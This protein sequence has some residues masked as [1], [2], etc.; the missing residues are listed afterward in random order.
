M[1]PTRWC[2]CQGV[3]L[4]LLLMPPAHILFHFTTALSR[5]MSEDYPLDWDIA[6]RLLLGPSRRL[7]QRLELASSGRTNHPVLQLT[8]AQRHWFQALLE[9]KTWTHARLAQLGDDDGSCPL[10]P[11]S[12]HDEVHRLWHCPA[13]ADV[14]SVCGVA[15]N[16]PR[17]NT[18]TV[19]FETSG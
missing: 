18:L 14:R 2:T 7:S 19:P 10:C 13:T 6:A 1:S 15:R 17:W 8:Q 16:D 11:A 12:W 4:D 3:I 5:D 9:G